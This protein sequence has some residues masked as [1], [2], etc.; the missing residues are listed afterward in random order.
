MSLFKTF[1]YESSNGD[2]DLSYIEKNNQ[3]FINGDNGDIYN[4]ENDESLIYK[5]SISSL[6]QNHEDFM[7][8]LGNLFG[9]IISSPIYPEEKFILETLTKGI[10]TNNLKNKLYKFRTI[11]L[12][13][14]GRKPEK[15]SQ[16]SHDSSSD[17]NCLLKIQNHF[18]NFIINLTNEV[19][20][21]ENIKEDFKPVDYKI[22]SNVNHD[23]FCKL[24][25]Y[26][27]KNILEMDISPKY[28]SKRN[29]SNRKTLNKIYNYSH[30]LNDFFNINYLELFSEYHNNE[31]PLLKFVFKEKEIELCETES[32]Y[33]L[34]NNKNNKAKKIEKALSNIAKRFFI[35]DI[36][37]FNKKLFQ[38][39][40]TIDLE[41]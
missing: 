22:K 31:K 37:T 27:I 11:L 21:K 36:S 2:L 17:D 8:S 19:L 24:K 7:L 34:L 26:A 5:N 35:D 25:K 13:K 4:E 29:D 38:T 40:E 1:H 6:N 33:Y 15:S 32:F 12:K 39:K 41:E 10:D 14:R 3:Y 20:K 30:W 9:N 23:F 18:F 16:K 28:K